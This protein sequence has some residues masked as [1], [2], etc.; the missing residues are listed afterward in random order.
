M[1]DQ[2]PTCSTPVRRIPPLPA[3]SVT[4]AIYAC[5]VYANL[6]FIVTDLADFRFFPPFK[7]RVNANENR[8]LG[9][10]YFNIA[11]SLAAG[12]G[13]R[14]PFNDLTGPTAWMPP[15]LP[16]IEA[17]LLWACGDDRDTVVDLQVAFSRSYDQG[18]F[19]QKIDYQRD[20]AAPI[21]DEDRQWLDDL[22][23]HHKLR[24]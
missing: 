15:V 24:K 16:L 3:L 1:I 2:A 4:V 10:E 22:L 18:G 11:R 20:P 23:K 6:S 7:Q 8:Q 12:R 14:D 5:C 19:A 9:A 17:G 13:F 21:A